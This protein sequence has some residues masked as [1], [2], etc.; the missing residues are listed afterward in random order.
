MKTILTP[1]ALK[2]GSEQA[3]APALRHQVYFSESSSQLG[4]LTRDSRIGEGRKCL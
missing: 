4:L 2:P 1:L 3:V